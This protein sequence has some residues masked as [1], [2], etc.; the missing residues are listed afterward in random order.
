M[1]NRESLALTGTEEFT[2]HDVHDEWSAPGF[3]LAEDTR[4]IE[5]DSS[6][7]GYVEVWNNS[8][9]HVR[10]VAWVSID[11]SV[12][13]DEPARRLLLWAKERALEKLHLAPDD[14]RV[15]FQ[16]FALER[17]QPGIRRITSLGMTEQ[18]RYYRMEIDL[19]TGIA[20]PNV[21]E[22]YTIRTMRPDEAR[23]TY[24]SIHLAFAD[25]YGRPRNTDEDEQ[26]N[27]WK[28]YF[29]ESAEFDP[30]LIFV[31]EH[32]SGELAGASVCWPRRGPNA[33]MGWVDELGVIPGHRKQGV[34]EALLRHSFMEFMKRGKKTAGLGVDATSLTGATRLYEKCGMHVVRTT[35]SFEEELRSGVDYRKQ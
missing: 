35:I 15:I 25:H 24:H 18:R 1:F 19:D 9:P 12:D 27:E 30:E 21:P 2:A 33:E 14:A 5:D 17:D 3:S 7:I 29:V 10:P 4:V 20:E 11:P 23:A 8:K 26:F 31:A 28:H 32:Q 13:D 6:P 34:A 16:T 22:G